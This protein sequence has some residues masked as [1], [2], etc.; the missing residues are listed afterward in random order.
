MGTLR[1]SNRLLGF[2]ISEP[3]PRVDHRLS[4]PFAFHFCLSIKN[5]H[6]AHRDPLRSRPQTAQIVGEGLR[7]HRYGA[8]DQVDGSSTPARFA[9]DR[10]L[11]FYI[12]ADV[13]DVNAN[14]V[15]FTT[16]NPLLL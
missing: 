3:L 12:M 6:R 7:E 2:F 9:V 8:V 5:K 14:F 4:E 13:G 1:F 15:Q 11:F 10:A 16:P